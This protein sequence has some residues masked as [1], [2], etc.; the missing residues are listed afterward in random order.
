[1]RDG[2]GIGD[3]VEWDREVRRGRRSGGGRLI[4]QVDGRH[5]V[6]EEGVVGVDVEREIGVGMELQ[7]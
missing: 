6:V 2:G 4:G 5:A 3:R 7:D 1:M